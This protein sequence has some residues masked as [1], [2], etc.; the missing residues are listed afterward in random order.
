MRE[1]DDIVVE[2]SFSLQGEP[3][4]RGP[5]GPLRGTAAPSAAR[6]EALP[7][8]G[9]LNGALVLD[10]AA[11]VEV[12]EPLQ[13]DHCGCALDAVFR[14]AKGGAVAGASSV[15]Q[16]PGLGLRLELLHGAR[17]LLPA[18]LLELD[19]GSIVTV[20]AERPLGD[21]WTRL[22]AVCTQDD[23]WL[24]VDGFVAARREIVGEPARLTRRLELG[25]LDERATVALRG[26]LGGLRVVAGVPA[27][28][29]RALAA[30]RAADFDPIGGPW[31]GLG[32][33]QPV[34]VEPQSGRRR[35]F[36]DGEVHC[37]RTHRTRVVR[38]RVL[39]CYRKYGGA[40]ALGLALSIDEPTGIAGVT[41]SRFERGMILS[42]PQ[43]VWLIPEM[44]VARWLDSGAERGLLGVPTGPATVDGRGHT[45]PFERGALYCV[46]GECFVLRGPIADEYRRLGGIDGPWGAPRSST[47]SLKDPRCTRGRFEKVTVYHSSATGLQLLSPE[48]AALHER[49]GGH[50]GKLGLPVAAATRLQPGMV[51]Q[52]FQH[53]VILDRGA[54]PFVA[55]ALRL[56]LGAVHVRWMKDGGIRDYNAEPYVYWRIKVDGTTVR[57]RRYPEEGEHKASSFPLAQEYIVRPLRVGTLVEMSVDVYDADVGKD[58]RIGGLGERFDA[59]NAWQTGG[60]A[61]GIQKNKNADWIDDKRLRT[62]HDLEFDYSV[63]FVQEIDESAH[64]RARDFWRFNNFTGPALMSRRAYVE[65][66]R[67]VEVAPDTIDQLLHPIDS[68]LYEAAFDTIADGG[69]CFGMS[70]EALYVR[71]GR[72]LLAR[73]LHERVGS[74]GDKVSVSTADDVEP[75]IRDL[76]NIKQAYQLGLGYLA[77]TLPEVAKGFVRGGMP[78]FEFVRERLRRGIDCVLCMN[79][80][81][82]DGEYSGHCVAPYRC[83]RRQGSRSEPHRIWVADPNLVWRTRSGDC[84]AI[85][86]AEDGWW[87]AVEYK[88]DTV[89]VLSFGS[90]MSAPPFPAMLTA[91]SFTTL[92]E[93]PRTVTSGL[94]YLALGLGLLAFG[95]LDPADGLMPGVNIV[96][97]P[98]GAPIRGVAL[99]ALG[100]VPDALN[101]SLRSRGPRPARFA[102]FAPTCGLHVREDRAGVAA[103]R[104]AVK[105]LQDGLPSVEWDHPADLAAARVALCM[106][107]G[108]QPHDVARVDATVHA[109]RGHTGLVWVDPVDRALLLRSAETQRPI[110]VEFTVGDARKGE[111]LRVDVPASAAGEA[112]RLRVPDWR[113]PGDRVTV[114]RLASAD[115]GVLS[116]SRVD[117]R[118]V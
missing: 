7:G 64:F 48:F 112:V 113:R 73:P 67:D 100:G 55:T 104:L 115:G 69:N 38:G 76:I 25:R 108:G 63:G 33:E 14:P 21:G 72:S 26:E 19:G 10:G 61:D 46:D 49:L 54:G 4:W 83:E 20:I 2:L 47:T 45:Q 44:F 86:V 109:A 77:G 57:N 30:A 9:E 102:M 22:T 11:G 15:V 75:E 18:A 74:L 85:E 101:L 59:A 31:P 97:L 39:H 96:P 35:V 50:A 82:E 84:S 17:G 28:F 52:D 92:D 91:A 62:T 23:L 93:Q 40:R 90:E 98:L 34:D 89:R 117:V 65:T 36:A 70:L 42:G 110:T 78:A 66:F 51:G 105:G 118:R 71:A 94:F 80:R 32:A 53:G 95:D 29:R 6:R 16:A 41:R 99:A 88:G 1:T 3:T 114:E 27:E 37:T 79:I 68:M 13:L 43:S 116:R 81:K 103:T 87:R 5:G 106:R 111:R 107:R 58:D 12:Q 8:W 56:V 60:G 24:L